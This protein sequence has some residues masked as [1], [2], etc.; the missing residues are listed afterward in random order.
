MRAS[1]EDHAWIQS[2]RHCCA[3]GPGDQPHNAAS[4]HGM[5]SSCESKRALLS[6][7]SASAGYMSELEDV[8]AGE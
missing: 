5:F 1:D 6:P 7:G 8:D 3:T 4:H 2:A